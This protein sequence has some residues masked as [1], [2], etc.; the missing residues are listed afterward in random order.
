M[1]ITLRAPGS[2]SAALL[3]I[4]GGATPVFA[5]FKP[6]PSWPEVVTPFFH[7]A[8]LAE[9]AARAGE[10]KSRPGFAIQGY[11]DTKSMW[12]VLKGGK[13]QLALERLQPHSPLAVG[14]IVLFN[15][16]DRMVVHYIAA[17]SRDGTEAYLTGVNC[18]NSDGWFSRSRI[19]WIVRE[20]ITAPAPGTKA[21]PVSVAAS[22]P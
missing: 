7:A 17:L 12:P 4:L 20:I 16:G 11:R 2:L 13:E 9:G 5:G 6:G 19:V 18:R 8:S 21:P 10:W 1:R 22:M 14:Q 3:L 15:R